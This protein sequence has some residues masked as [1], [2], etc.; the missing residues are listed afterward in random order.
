MEAQRGKSSSLGAAI[1]TL[2]KREGK[3]LPELEA[4]YAQDLYGKHFSSLSSSQKGS[5]WRHIVKN[6]DHLKLEPVI[7]QNGW[8]MQVGG[9]SYSLLRL[10]YITWLPLKI[11]L[12]LRLMKVLPLEEELPEPQP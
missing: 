6:P 9:Y 1:A 5:V 11:K 7:L 2:M 12:G 4:K 8:G 10:L 3:T